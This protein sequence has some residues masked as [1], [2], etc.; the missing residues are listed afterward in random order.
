MCGDFFEFSPT[1]GRFDVVFDYTFLCAMPPSLREKWAQK[2]SK[3]V[4]TNTGRLVTLIFP[5]GDFK[6][7]L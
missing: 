5:I 4:K 1:E 2:M 6:G 3:L 7:G